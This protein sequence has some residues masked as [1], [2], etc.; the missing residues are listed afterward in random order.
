MIF[1]I[2]QTVSAFT[3]RGLNTGIRLQATRQ[4]AS[5]STIRGKLVVIITT[6]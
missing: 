5:K 6:V 1:Q 2:F 3:S 4:F